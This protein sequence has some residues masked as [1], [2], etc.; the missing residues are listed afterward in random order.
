LDATVI[1]NG[2]GDYTVDFPGL[3]AVDNSVDVRANDEGSVCFTWA[4][5]SSSLN[6]RI[7][8]HCVRLVR[9]FPPLTTAIDSR[10]TLAVGQ[11]L[12]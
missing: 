12:G 9:V 1:R 6:L 5:Q 8:V 3:A 11:R 10:F 4:A 7:N 2:P